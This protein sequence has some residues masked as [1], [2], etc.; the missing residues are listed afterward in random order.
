M[1]RIVDSRPAGPATKAQFAAF[2]NHIGLPL[3]EEYREFLREHNGGR[4]EPDAFPVRTELGKQENTVLCFFPL[5]SLRSGKAAV[6][7]K[8]ELRTWPLHRAWE[9]LQH[10]LEHLHG[11][12]LIDPLLPIGTD[13]S[14]NYLCLVLSGPRSG[15]VVFFDHETAKTRSLA[16]GFREFLALLRPRKPAGKD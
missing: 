1:A 14:G 6:R 4:P 8:S 2:E 12:E 13:G 10:D 3:S 7:K 9:D 15:S 16:R 11:R 5:R